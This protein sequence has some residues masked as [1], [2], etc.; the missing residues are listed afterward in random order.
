[1]VR[2]QGLFSLNTG[3][4]SREFSST[5]SRESNAHLP[6]HSLVPSSDVVLPSQLSRP[7]QG[8]F[9]SRS[10]DEE[11]SVLDTIREKVTPNIDESMLELADFIQNSELTVDMLLRELNQTKTLN[12][13]N[14]QGVPNGFIEKTLSA[15]EE[16]VYHCFLRI[17]LEVKFPGQNNE[18]N[19]QVNDQIDFI[20]KIKFYI[21]LL[22]WEKKE[23][24]LVIYS[25]RSESLIGPIIEEFSVLTGIPVEVKYGKTGALVSL[26][27]EEGSK[28]PADV[29][30][31]QDPGGLGAVSDMLSPMSREVCNLI[32]A[33]AVAPRAADNSCKWI[34]IT[35]RAR[36]LVYNPDVTAVADLPKSMEDLTDPKYK[37]K[38]GWAPT[39]GSFQA[40]VTGMRIYWGEEKTKA[41]LEGIMANEPIIYPKNTPQVQA[42]AD[43]EKIGRAHV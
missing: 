39:N 34:G 11:S 28:T 26:L 38:L 5:S 8:T 20:D 4:S 25:G 2:L 19:S 27:Q 13:S 14:Q 12:T 33:W 32:P 9:L 21:D 23:K 29:F 24:E 3:T 37:G 22:N 18:I 30:Y 31:A 41:W 10:A 42:A 40:M 15:E 7:P 17:A 35:G 6:S 1:M 16:R 43:Q 36:V